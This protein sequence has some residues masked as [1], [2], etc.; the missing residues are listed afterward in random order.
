MPARQRR[1]PD[2]QVALDEWGRPI[3]D[4]VIEFRDRAARDRFNALLLAA[5]RHQHPE[6]FAG[7]VA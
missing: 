4:A 5:L 3:Y 7:A 1:G 2:D 6:A